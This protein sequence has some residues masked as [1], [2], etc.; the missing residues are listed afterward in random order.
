[1]AK[2]FEITGVKELDRKLAAITTRMKKNYVRKGV[3]AGGAIVIKAAK[4]NLP[5]GK[6]GRINKKGDKIKGLRRSITQRVKTYPSGVIIS[7]VGPDY[8]TAPHGHLVEFGHKMVGH[9]PGKKNLGV[10][11]AHPFLR[12]AVDKSKQAVMT[13]V[14]RKIREGLNT[15]KK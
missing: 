14:Q 5:K 8:K 2:A 6:R 4:E 7:V 10:V 3:R 12:P 9:K 11:R 1:M 15:E 13:A